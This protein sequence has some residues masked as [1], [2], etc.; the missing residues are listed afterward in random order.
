MCCSE[1]QSTGWKRLLMLL[2]PALPAGVISTSADGAVR[3]SAAASRLQSAPQYIDIL[4]PK[5][6]LQW[7]FFF[8]FPFIV[9]QACD[10]LTSQPRRCQLRHQNTSLMGKKKKSCQIWACRWVFE[11]GVFTWRKK[12]MYSVIT[13]EAFRGLTVVQKML[14]IS[15]WCRSWGNSC[16]D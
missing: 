5:R 15:I 12:K 11:W 14:E 3:S 10:I 4:S 7:T 2:L 6:G 16:V 13:L 8:K 1:S 9:W